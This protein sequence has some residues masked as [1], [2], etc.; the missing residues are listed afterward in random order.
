MC[1]EGRTLWEPGPTRVP[2]TMTKKSGKSPKE[3]VT[4]KRIHRARHLDFQPC[5]TANK[6]L[7]IRQSKNIAILRRFFLLEL[8]IV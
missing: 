2:Q 4:E 7:E 5:R 1:A 3:N 8:N 6:T